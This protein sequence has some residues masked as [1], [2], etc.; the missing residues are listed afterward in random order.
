M[1]EEPRARLIKNGVVVGQMWR[2]SATDEV[3]ISTKDGQEF[4]FD[5]V[6][7]DFD[8][9]G[10]ITSGT[11]TIWDGTNNHIPASVVQKAGLD[12]DTLDGT[13]SANYA[14]TDVAETFD[15]GVNFLGTLTKSGNA[16][17]TESWVT[18][19][20]KAADANAL[21]GIDSVNYA[22]TDVAETFDA[23]V[24]VTD[25]LN[26]VAQDL[27][28]VTGQD[29]KIYHHNGAAAITADGVST[30]ATGYYVWSATDLEWKS[31]VTY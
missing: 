10:S 29:G 6:A 15:A 2:D 5:N 1:S 13:D 23:A 9:P 11:T 21:D 3:V 31:M 14:R 16:V 26:V 30:S 12:A 25:N 4:R 22:R 19:T 20:A 17:A 18:T 24:G 28:L 7:G 27:S 8:V